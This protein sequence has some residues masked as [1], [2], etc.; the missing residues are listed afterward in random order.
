MG[1]RKWLVG[2]WYSVLR[3]VNQVPGPRLFCAGRPWSERACFLLLAYS[4]ES[5]HQQRR[6]KVLSNFFFCARVEMSAAFR[7]IFWCSRGGCPRMSRRSTQRIAEGRILRI[8][9]QIEV[10]TLLGPA[11]MMDGSWGHYRCIS[12]SGRSMEH[13]S[14]VLLF[15]CEPGQRVRTQLSPQLICSTAVP[16]PGQIGLPPPGVKGQDRV[17]GP[18]APAERW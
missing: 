10:T 3:R 13:L 8:D 5:R 15:S 18:R 17:P 14:V 11:A 1:T 9:A 7:E 4:S 2:G 16:F 6:S 12:P